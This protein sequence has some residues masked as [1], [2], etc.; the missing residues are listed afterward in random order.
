MQ[1]TS[2]LGLKT[3]TIGTGAWKTI[4]NDSVYAMNLNTLTTWTMSSGSLVNVG[5][6][7]ML[8]TTLNGLTSLY[9]PTGSLQNVGN[10]FMQAVSM[11]SL[12][13]ITFA[14]GAM[15]TLG[16]NFMYAESLPSLISL[17]F[18][19]GSLQSVG[20]NFM[21][22]VNFSSLQNLIFPA[23][24]FQGIATGGF[25][26]GITLSSGLTI[27]L[28]YTTGTVIPL[29]PTITKPVFFYPFIKSYGDTGRYI[30][31]GGSYLTFQNYYQYPGAALITNYLRSYLGNWVIPTITGQSSGNFQIYMKIFSNLTSG[32]IRNISTL[33]R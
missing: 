26:N 17:T 16:S 25:M 28:P 21:Y 22:G 8:G 18:P 3:L 10:F 4:G 24:S 9:F 11:N 12:K 1:R 32:D 6:G 30:A 7:F 33:I 23:G 5:N 13:S 2:L 19:V 31:T 27:T 29:P 20:I 14:S 15:K